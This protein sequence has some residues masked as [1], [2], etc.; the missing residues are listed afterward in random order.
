M[1]KI[2][3]GDVV[4]LNGGSPN[5]TVTWVGTANVTVICWSQRLGFRLDTVPIKAVTVIGSDY[6][7][8]K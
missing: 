8:Q 6:N 4:R 5:L 7:R 3:I 1:N 2:K